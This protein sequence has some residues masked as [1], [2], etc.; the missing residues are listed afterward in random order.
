MKAACLFCRL[1]IL[2][3]IV[4]G[5]PPLALA[6]AS[7]QPG[8]SG[9]AWLEG[10]DGGFD[11]VGPRPGLHPSGKNDALFQLELTAPGRTITGM[12]LRNVDGRLAIWDTYPRSR[13]WQLAV[14]REHKPLNRPDGSLY[15]PL[16]QGREILGIRVEDNGSVSGGKTRFKLTVFFADGGKAVFPVQAGRPASPPAPATSFVVGAGSSW[17]TSGIYSVR[18][19]AGR[20]F[21]S[22]WTLR[23]RGG[24]IKGSSKWGCCPGPRVDPLQGTVRGDSLTI[25]RDCRGQG[26][27]GPCRQ[28]YSGRKVGPAEVQGTFTLNGRKI[29]AWI[30]RLPAT[31]LAPAAATGAAPPLG[32]SGY[33]VEVAAREIYIDQGSKKGTKVGDRFAVLNA[34]GREIAVLQV[35][36]VYPDVS[37]AGLVQGQRGA[38]A[39]GQRLGKPGARPAPPPPPPAM[40][41]PQPKPAPMPA[42]VPATPAAAPSPAGGGLRIGVLP[43]LMETQ[44]S[45][46]GVSS[47][48]LPAAAVAKALNVYR[49]LAARAIAPAQAEELFHLEGGALQMAM[50]RLGLDAIIKWGVSQQEYDERA[51]VFVVLIRR[52]KVD[53]QNTVSIMVDA[54]RVSSRFSRMV[55]RLVGESLGYI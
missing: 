50:E 45:L 51:S 24:Q 26:H 30:M 12:Q 43:A 31:A 54:D 27:Q 53:D 10:P 5:G 13:H 39:A 52:Q 55:T 42:S 16:G 18:T 36:R 35:L 25:T 37:L 48:A 7:A 32:V 9:S 40:A 28:V 19:F 2:M 8:V 4:A 22:D 34:Q 11:W 17:L 14:N 47:A 1:V 38:L 46:I 6:Q 29:G 3:L 20:E 23:V 41:A 33:V 15:A 21:P 49:P 44:G